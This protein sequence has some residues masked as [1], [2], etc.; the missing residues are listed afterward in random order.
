MPVYIQ[1]L[2]EEPYEASLSRP[3]IPKQ[4]AQLADGANV[5]KVFS[6]ECSDRNTSARWISLITV[7]YKL[8][9]RFFLAICT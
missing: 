5:A 9:R 7:N 8:D 4:F 1:T 2:L 3:L 6:D